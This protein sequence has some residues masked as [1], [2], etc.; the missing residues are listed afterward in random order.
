M[1]KV[2]TGIVAFAIASSAIAGEVQKKS[3]QIP[4][5]KAG[6]CSITLL[7]A[8]GIKPLAGAKLTLQSVKDTKQIISSEASKSG[9]CVVNVENGRYIL[10]VNDKI[11]TLFDVKDDGKLAWCRIVVSEKP[12][13]VGGQAEAAA[14]GSG[15][16]AFMGL[17]GGAAVAA[18]TAAGIVGVA[19]VVVGGDYA[20]WWDVDGIDDSGDDDDDSP[21]PTPEEAPA[22]A[23]RPP[24]ASR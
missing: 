22:A 7:G 20:D 8:D 2:M 19:G 11:M 9:L 4:S 18:A 6:K 21:A 13:L 14:A 5:V 16:F 1:V 24:P 15:G 17:N 12:M 10:S 23:P 3:E